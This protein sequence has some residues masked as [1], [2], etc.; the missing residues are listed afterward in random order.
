MG[1]RK[2]DLREFIEEKS[3]KRLNELRNIFSAAVGEAFTPVV[4][5]AYADLAS[6]EVK[7]DTFHR[8]LDQAIETHKKMR[9]EF[10]YSRILREVNSHIL[11]LRKGIVEDQ[12]RYAVYNILERSTNGLMEGLDD[13]AAD[14]AK[15]HAKLV[16]EYQNLSKLTD[17]LTTIIDAAHNGDKAFKQLKELGVNL[18]GFEGTNP[19]LPAIV[20]LSV[21]PCLLNGDCK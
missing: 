17:E 7:A 16:A 11:G 4:F 12:T 9:T 21:D 5:D 1:I 20:K 6:L 8:A 3:N 15:R 14:V 2:V 19:N 13:I 10:K 18:D